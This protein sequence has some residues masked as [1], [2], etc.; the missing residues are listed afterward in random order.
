[1]ATSRPIAVTEVAP[2]PQTARGSGAPAPG[3]AVERP[4]LAA[5]EST[6]AEPA[7]PKLSEA[8]TMPA[9]LAPSA[10]S[11]APPVSAT[12]MT[13]EA[14]PQRP[15]NPADRATYDASPLVVSD[16]PSVETPVA[17]PGKRGTSAGRGPSIGL[18]IGL[19]LALSV[20][21]VSVVRYATLE[22]VEE[23]P[24]SEDNPATKAAISPPR[25]PAEPS[26]PKPAAEPTKAAAPGGTEN[27]PAEVPKQAGGP[28]PSPPSSGATEKSPDKDQPPTGEPTA[29][30]AKD[31]RRGATA[32][33]PRGAT[34]SRHGS[35]E[36]E[37]ATGGTDSAPAATAPAKPPGATPGTGQ[38]YDP[39]SPLPPAGE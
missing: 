17:S 9:L 22:E 8:E 11:P 25:A 37:G 3:G 2:G 23:E 29:S 36:A 35:G 15:T 32:M 38:P 12:A 14:K 10:V 16:E 18:G 19:A 13:I 6:R 4:A 5:P 21:V 1:V 39:D 24:T 26:P 31:P 33:R 7:R 28:E 20:A 27:G 30:G 34:P